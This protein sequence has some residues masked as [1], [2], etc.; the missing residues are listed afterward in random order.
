MSARNRRNVAPATSYE[1]RRSKA[2]SERHRVNSEMGQLSGS[3]SELEDAD[4]SVGFHGEHHHHEGAWVPRQKTF[5]R[6]SFWKRR[7]QERIRRSQQVRE[8]S[9]G[10]DD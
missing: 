10:D 1:E 6:R 9:N 5:W 2:R 8:L 4:I 7:S 3:A